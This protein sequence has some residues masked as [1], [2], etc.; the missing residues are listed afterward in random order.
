VNKKQGQMSSPVHNEQLQEMMKRMSTQIMQVRKDTIKNEQA[1][2]NV[3]GID[4]GTTFSCAAVWKNNEIKIITTTGK[5]TIPSVVA[6]IP[7]TGENPDDPVFEPIVGEQAVKKL[8]A[9]A[10]RKTKHLISNTVYEAK[11]FIGRTLND[12]NIQTDIKKYPFAIVPGENNNAY[13]KLRVGDEKHKV[14]S[15]EEVSANILSTLKHS[16]EEFIGQPVEGAVITVPAY[17]TDHQ[18]QATIDAGKIAGLDVKA[19][20]NEPTAAALAYAF[21]EHKT[22]AIGDNVAKHTG[23]QNLLVF[24]LGGGTFDVTVLQHD[25]GYVEVLSTVGHSHLGGSDFDRALAEYLAAE[26]MRT[27]NITKNPLDDTV[28]LLQ[29]MNISREAKIDLSNTNTTDIFI[30]LEEDEFETTVTRAKFES[31]IEPLI[32]Q[33]IELVDKAVLDSKLKEDD[34]DDIILVGGSTN[35][36][37]VRDMIRTH[38]RGKK[39]CADINADEAVAMGAAIRAAH[40]ALTKQQKRGTL[41][42]DLKIVDVTPMHVGIKVKGDQMDVIVPANSPLPVHSKAIRYRT[43]VDN[44]SSTQIDIIEGN[45][46]HA[47]DNALLGSFVISGFPPLPKGKVK[48]AIVIKIDDLFGTLDVE[49]T[50]LANEEA[51]LQEKVKIQKSKGVLSQERIQLARKEVEKIEKK[52]EAKLMMSNGL[53]ALQTGI[54][55]LKQKLQSNEI[56]DGQTRRDVEKAVKDCQKWIDIKKDQGYDLGDMLRWLEWIRELQRRIDP[57]LE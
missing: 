28:T 39:I 15:P 26:Y 34:L 52:I 17:F 35:I 47:P 56:S 50:C 45:S 3:I 24:D 30:E 32:R 46:M 43:T 1:A 38:F 14:L 16:A 12:P 5:R 10:A 49:A 21:T 53:N 23:K 33:C 20:I 8:N 29:F 31:L 48:V 41:L 18:R 51:V 27:K 9:R 4:L 6:F 40:M 7:T 2:C 54:N 44:Q 36:P 11:R 55:A 57:L 22:R 13:V 25:H 19:V 37:L 42:E